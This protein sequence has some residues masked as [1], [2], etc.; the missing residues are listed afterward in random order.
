M[1]EPIARETEYVDLL[2]TLTLSPARAGDVLPK[3]E[4]LTAREREELFTLADSHHVLL[5]S[6]ESL[7]AA[8]PGPKPELAEWLRH[9]IAAERERIANALQFLTRICDEL[10]SANCPT[11][12]MKSLD[13]WPDLGNDLDLY[14]TGDVAA[15]QK[16]II[17]KFNA[18]LEAPSWGDRLAHK[19]NFAIPGLRELVEVHVQRLGQTG[20]HTELA[21]RF[22][23]RRVS[24][25]LGGYRFFV[26]A[27]EER[28]IVATLQRMYRHFYARVCDVVNIARLAD[29]GTIH[30]DELKSASEEAGI[31]PGVATFLV[32]VS[33]YVTQYRGFGLALPQ[34]VTDAAR[35]GGNLVV[36]RK[37]FLRIPMWPQGAGLYTTQLTKTA[38]RGDAAAALRLSLLPGLASAAAVAAKL[39]GSDK[40]IW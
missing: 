25:E 22:V 1:A 2:L 19:S 36:T 24:A 32:I 39:T 26:P 17:E 8:D 11:V 7:L 3:V 27:P 20:E 23:S 35:F 12:V 38:M 37:R 9:C 31:W 18:T 29:S 30:F 6:F 16:T 15:V 10:E 5:R 13:H 28:V 33:D 4:R 34:T 14:T 21:R 40:G